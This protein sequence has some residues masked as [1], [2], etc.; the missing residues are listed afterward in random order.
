MTL[1]SRID[2]Q[3]GAQTGTGR[4][5]WR[6]PLLAAVVALI[7]GLPGL[8]FLPPM[9]RDESRFAQATVQMLETGDFVAPY[10]Q[11]EPRFKKPVGVY[12][13]Q[14]A[15]VSVLSSAEDRQIWAFRIPSLLGAMLA[16]A[17]CAWGAA[18]FYGPRLGLLAGGILGA[19]QMLAFEAGIAKT[20]A[21]LCGTI[22]L[23]MA[24]FAHIYLASRGEGTSG[25]RTQL[26]FW[27]GIAGSA[28]D[29]GPVGPLIALLAG[30]TLWAA[31]RKAPWLPRLGWGWGLLIL[32][33]TLLPWAAAVTVATDGAF[34]SAAV[35]GDL[36]PKLIGGHES[37]GAPPGYYALLLPLLI[38]PATLMLPAAAVTA[39]RDR[40]ESGV[41]FALA[42]LVLPWI[43]FEIVP[44]KLPHYTLPLFGAV[45]WLMVAALQNFIGTRLRLIG[46][47]LSAL[48]GLVFAALTIAL[49]V[50]YGGAGDLTWGA[51]TATLFLAAGA[52]GALL[53]WA[54]APKSALV[55][56]GVLG[57]LAHGAFFG[58][59]GPGL[60]PLWTSQRI[61]RALDTAHL[62]PRDG[63]AAGPVEV[64][65]YAEP[66]LVFA[67]GTKTGLKD[68]AHAAAAIAAGRPAVVEKREEPAF[69]AA[70]AAA[71][72]TPH[73]A[74]T[75][76]GKDY[77]NGDDV[78]LTLYRGEPQ[79]EALPD[80][81][82]DPDRR[83][84]RARRPAE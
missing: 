19:S 8:F 52:A 37:H 59:F 42:W 80:E 36:A 63:V 1:E 57:V 47:I 33:V 6:G 25:R 46:A 20:D 67:L 79:K 48:T 66:S 78:V 9:D 53:L 7:A 27:L 38:F 21:V 70:M 58:G 62:N 83:S 54:H 34:W 51:L 28:L 13:L 35:G 41:R 43:M 11:D 3:L 55:T 12:W 30:I 72:L 18:A 31:D 77:S 24:A 61:V 14:A 64:A 73:P 49:T 74:G 69:R 56:A 5:S 45:A 68:G 22:T 82:Q 81:P 84:G 75:V 50:Q 76:A 26:L 17:A 4:R 40:R 15:S 23:A 29:K 65:G 44:T 60:G 10:Y 71:G 2:E 39:W 16:A 32:A